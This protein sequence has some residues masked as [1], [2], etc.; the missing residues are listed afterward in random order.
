MGRYLC[1]D[2]PYDPTCVILGAAFP[3]HVESIL[4]RGWATAASF[5]LFRGHCETPAERG[6]P[7]RLAA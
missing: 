5:R 1:G 7:V 4:L 2:A 6:S 3:R